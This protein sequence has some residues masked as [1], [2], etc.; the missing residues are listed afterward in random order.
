MLETHITPYLQLYY[1]FTVV[2]VSIF[3]ENIKK[4]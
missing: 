4:I 1:N 3:L 2:V